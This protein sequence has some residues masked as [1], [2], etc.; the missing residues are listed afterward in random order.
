MATLKQ[1]HQQ[2]TSNLPEHAS[3]SANIRVQTNLAVGKTNDPSEQEAD[4]T[5]DKVM[6]M[7]SSQ[8]SVIQRKCA[9]C[10]EQEKA[11]RKPLA[12]FIQQKGTA[13]GTMAS[14]AVSSKISTTKGSGDSMDN[15]TKS[16][17]ESRFGTDFSSVKIHTG[18]EAIQ[19]NRELGAK[20]FTVG[21]DIY[22]NQGQYQPES[23][24]GKH[25]LAHELTHTVQQG[26]ISPK[27]QT[28]IQKAGAAPVPRKTIWV[29]VGFDSSAVA[30]DKTM[31][32]LRASIAVEKA[33]ISS[34][35]TAKTK[36]CDVDVKVHYDW[37]RYNKPAP[38]DL[39]YDNDDAKDRALNDKNLGKITAPNGGI[40]I[41]VT[42]SK[43]SQT[44]QGVRIFPRANTGTAGVLWNPT[45]AADDTIA[46]E[47][48]HAAGYVGDIES[49]AHN[50]D[51]TNIM[52]PGSV[53]TG[54][55]PDDSWCD[56][57]ANTAV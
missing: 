2:H 13:G 4:A 34:C 14:E 31:K 30:D 33:A 46:H 11:Q 47:S 52:S 51:P 32:K 22:F 3:S 48:G 39:D 45:L 16:F 25:L 15:S 5:A 7:P 38:T 20:A 28:K 54:S 9:H 49:N 1:V 21:S 6:R 57:M 53:R 12:P 10:E 17:M 26:A 50:S 36:A 8:Q 24:S 18:N 19:M 41:L 29:N 56:Q 55:T 42:L 44:W 35:C 40:K 43:L 23:N 37:V 27:A